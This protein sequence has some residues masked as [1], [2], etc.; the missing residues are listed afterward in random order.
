MQYKIHIAWRYNNMR[1]DCIIFSHTTVQII[2]I[3]HDTTSNYQSNFMFALYYQIQRQTSKRT[4]SAL[5]RMSKIAQVY[6]YF[7]TQS[8]KLT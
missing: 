7:T 5:A 3:L 6:I 4:E 2:Y 1:C 8:K